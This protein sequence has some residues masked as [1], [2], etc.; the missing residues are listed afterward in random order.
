MTVNMQNPGTAVPVS[1][2]LRIEEW[3][4]RLRSL[5]TLAVASKMKYH[6]LPGSSENEYNQLLDMLDRIIK[7]MENGDVV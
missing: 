3:I 6:S 4:V 1:P 5:Y 7:D 2:I